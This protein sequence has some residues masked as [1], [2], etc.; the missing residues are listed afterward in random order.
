[1]SVQALWTVEAVID[2]RLGKAVVCK[3][4]TKDRAI[5]EISNETSNGRDLLSQIQVGSVIKATLEIA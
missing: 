4:S 3:A 1:M 5:F 2:D